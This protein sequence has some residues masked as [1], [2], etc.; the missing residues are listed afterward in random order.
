VLRRI[1]SSYPETKP[2]WAA[3]LRLR[4]KMLYDE[5]EKEQE[6]RRVEEAAGNLPRVRLT[7]EHRTFAKAADGTSLT[8]PK[9]TGRDEVELELFPHE[10]PATVANFLKLVKRGFY[11]GTRFHWAEAASM[12]VGGDPNTKNADTSEDGTG[13]PGYV[14]PDEFRLP[15]A[16]LHFRG[17]VA[18]VESAAHTAG[19]QF[20]IELVPHPE[21]NHHLTVFGRV[22]RG[23]EGVDRIT[24]GRTN[25]RFGRFG[26]NI[27]GD[28]LVRAEVVR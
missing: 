23:Q 14:I 25:M 12:A 24:L 3:P 11:N 2:D 28:L 10:A 27:P 15:G 22:V 18:M 19:S 4:A 20:F 26:K 1:D 9:T 8:R 13:G 6:I 7:I 16:R 21:M 17:S 5:W